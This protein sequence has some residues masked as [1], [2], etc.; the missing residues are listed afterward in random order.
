[1]EKHMTNDSETGERV[2]MLQQVE[3]SIVPQVSILTDNDDARVNR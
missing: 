1:M 2:Q 3:S